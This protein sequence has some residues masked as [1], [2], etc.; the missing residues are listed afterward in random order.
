MQINKNNYDAL[1][2]ARG[3]PKEKIRHYGFAFEGKKVLIGQKF[4]VTIHGLADKE[5]LADIDCGVFAWLIGDACVFEISHLQTGIK[6]LRDR[7]INIFTSCF[8]GL[9]D[10]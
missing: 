7:F 8:E 10:A 1:L 6:S 9:D 4:F 3:I 5:N 2:I